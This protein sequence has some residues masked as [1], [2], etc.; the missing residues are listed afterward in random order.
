L[1]ERRRVAKGG[2]DALPLAGPEAM[3]QPQT[4]AKGAQQARTI[5]IDGEG[6]GNPLAKVDDPDS[7]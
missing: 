2:L 6:A 5:V 7:V 3:Q 4:K 1:Q